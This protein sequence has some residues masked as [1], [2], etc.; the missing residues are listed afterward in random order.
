MTQTATPIRGT[1]R[2]QSVSVQEPT[3]T[4]QLGGKRKL[5]LVDAIAQ[6]IGFMGPVFSI[7]FLVPLLVG[8]TSASGKGAG[9]AAPLAA[10]R[11]GHRRQPSGERDA[12]GWHLPLRHHEV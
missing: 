1:P 3:Q 5:T 12:G 10:D 9:G 2:R 11:A 7:A 6:S 8:V 4:G